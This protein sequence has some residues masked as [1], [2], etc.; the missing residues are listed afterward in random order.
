MWKVYRLPAFAH[1][2]GDEGRDGYKKTMN[3]ID[4]NMQEKG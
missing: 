1:Y 2:G 4:K 3:C